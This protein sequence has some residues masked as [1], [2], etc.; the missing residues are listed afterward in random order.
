MAP[1][2]AP[3]LTYS[4]LETFDWVRQTQV[5]QNEH[6]RMKTT[7]IQGN[8]DRPNWV[9]VLANTGALAS[10]GCGRQVA[11]RRT[12]PALAGGFYPLQQYD[13][14]GRLQPGKPPGTA[15]FPKWPKSGIRSP[16]TLKI[17]VQHE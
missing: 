9:M 3:V 10:S 15:D 12:S 7:A 16:E 6:S 4:N 13:T 11:N 17:T 5:K 14:L 8:L 1:A 2:K